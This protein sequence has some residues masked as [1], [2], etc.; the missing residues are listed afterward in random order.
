MVASRSVT[1][2]VGL[3]VSLAVSI[4]VWRAFDFPFLFVVVPFIPFLFR[5]GSN[6]VARQAVRRC[7]ACGFR[8]DDP[9]YDFCPRDGTR[10]E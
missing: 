3:A 7:P 5:S 8:T 2:A 1:A 4:V 6:G 10:L 9:E